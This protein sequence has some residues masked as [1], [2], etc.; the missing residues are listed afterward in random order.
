M[1]NKGEEEPIL[2][3]SGGGGQWGDLTGIGETVADF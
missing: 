2:A 1:K 3:P